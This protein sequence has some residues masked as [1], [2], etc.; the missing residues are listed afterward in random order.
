MSSLLLVA[1]VRVG[2]MEGGKDPL[3]LESGECKVHWEIPGVWILLAAQEVYLS[4]G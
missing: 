2:N 1:V 3:W 4:P